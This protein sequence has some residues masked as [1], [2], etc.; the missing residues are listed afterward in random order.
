MNRHHI[1]DFAEAPITCPMASGEK[2][3]RSL[4]SIRR[5]TTAPGL[6]I[7]TKGL[8]PSTNICYQHHDMQSAPGM[9][10]ALSQ[11]DAYIETKDP[12][13][14]V[15]AFSQGT[16]LA[17]IYLVQHSQQHPSESSPLKC[18]CF[19]SIGRPLD[20]RV[21]AQGELEQSDPRGTGWSITAADSESL[22]KSDNH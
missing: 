11:L 12:F 8:Y 13:D 5:I 4:A 1:F 10:L 17:T 14:A 6:P 7:E 9:S 2:L 18:I 16:A 22:R 3:I 19:F 15:L 21:L 20:H